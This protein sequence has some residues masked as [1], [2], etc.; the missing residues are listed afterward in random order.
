M[1]QVTLDDVLWW[2]IERH[3][4]GSERAPDTVAVARRAAVSRPQGW[5]SP[6]W[7]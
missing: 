6:H 7:W 4:L 2:R 1:C 5:I 3:F